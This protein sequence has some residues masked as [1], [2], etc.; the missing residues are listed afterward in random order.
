M[1]SRHLLACLIAGALAGCSRPE[2]VLA[3]KAPHGGTVT[4]LPEGLGSLEIVRVDVPGKSDQA[5][6]VLYFLGPDDK[7]ITPAPTA[8][9]LKPKERGA[10]P[11]SFKPAG[12]ADPSRAGALESPPFKADGDISGELSSTIGGKQITT[13][14]NIR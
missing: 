14:I 13:T 12:D 4:G 8:A 1:R 6:L 2:P 9:S 7:P 10:S 11:V 3:P 5:Q